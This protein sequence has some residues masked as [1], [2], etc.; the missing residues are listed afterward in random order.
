MPTN[1]LSLNSFPAA[2][3]SRR[4]TAPIGT[5]KAPFLINIFSL[6]RCVSSLKRGFSTLSTLRNW[7]Y[8]GRA[9]GFFSEP[10]TIIFQNLPV[11]E[12]EPSILEGFE[13]GWGFFEKIIFSLLRSRSCPPLPTYLEHAE[14]MDPKKFVCPH[15]GTV[16]AQPAEALPELYPAQ[17][18]ESSWKQLSQPGW[19]KSAGPSQRVIHRYFRER[20]CGRVFTYCSGALNLHS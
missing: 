10:K 13:F 14:R 20:E 11:W 5:H 3:W 7:F 18:P 17:A 8:H 9:V 19:E 2:L 12:N 16:P 15:N 1:A 6:A 4:C